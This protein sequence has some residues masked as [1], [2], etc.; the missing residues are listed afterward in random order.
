[1]TMEQNLEHRNHLLNE[2]IRLL[3]QYL[4]EAGPC[5]HAVNI[6]VCNIRHTLDEFGKD[7][8]HRTGGA[9]GWQYFRFDVDLDD[10]KQRAD[11]EASSAAEAMNNIGDIAIAMMKDMQAFRLRQLAIEADARNAAFR[12]GTIND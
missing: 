8:Y 7:C 10:P 11:H 3:Q 4:D 1:M 9:V 12:K 2:V 5:E 6:C